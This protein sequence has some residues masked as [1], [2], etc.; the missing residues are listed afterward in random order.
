MEGF[1]C[2]FVYLN[3]NDYGALRTLESC[4]QTMVLL[5]QIRHDC[6]ILRFSFTIN[7][8]LLSAGLGSNL[9]LS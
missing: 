9:Q 2:L 4:Q 7:K 6:D 8:P 3:I 5:V 1:P